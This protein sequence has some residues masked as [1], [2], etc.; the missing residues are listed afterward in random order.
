MTTVIVRW[1]LIPIWYSRRCPH[2]SQL[3]ALRPIANF[4]N[5]KLRQDEYAQMLNSL[6]CNSG[7]SYYNA[8]GLSL[9][10]ELLPPHPGF[11]F[12]DI[13]GKPPLQ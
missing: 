9:D 8:P 2:A 3:R 12:A 10:S 13:R 1:L 5:W 4:A 6:L 7:A 11:P